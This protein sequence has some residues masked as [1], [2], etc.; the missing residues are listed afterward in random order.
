MSE[1]TR[2]RLRDTYFSGRSLAYH[3]FPLPTHRVIYVKNPKAACST[4]L[5]WLSRVHHADHTRRPRNMHTEHGLPRPDDI[6]WPTTLGM[7]SG[8]GFRFTF[9]RDPLRRLESAYWDKIVHAPQEW[10]REPVQRILGISGTPTFE[11]FLSAIEQQDPAREMDPHWR[12]QH[13][14]LM[15]PLVSYDR[16]GKVETFADDVAAIRRATGLPAAPTEPRNQRR[17]Q[18]PSVYDTRPDLEE[19]ARALYALDLEL[20]GY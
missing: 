17:V 16:I 11:Q 10:W 9:V 7:L 15:Y 12:P 1:L 3:L 2:L 20:Y 19:R 8:D 18:R 4:V 13:V 5:L 14:N 6:G